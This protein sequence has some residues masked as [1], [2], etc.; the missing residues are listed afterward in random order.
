F[1]NKEAMCS[2]YFDPPDTVG[3]ANLV[4][5]LAAA[6]TQE[7]ADNPSA[8]ALYADPTYA[9]NYASQLVGGVLK[10]SCQGS[11]LNDGTDMSTT[12]NPDGSGTTDFTNGAGDLVRQVSV[13]ADGADVTREFDA[14]DT[15]PWSERDTSKTGDDNSTVVTTNNDNGTRDAT[16]V[17]GQGDPV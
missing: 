12:V 4:Q 10:D 16:L 3:Q 1:A 5:A 14:N 8:P 13:T 17:N 9:S 15:N 7:R 11:S 6:L 2:I